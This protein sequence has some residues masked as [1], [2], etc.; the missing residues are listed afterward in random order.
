MMV[1]DAGRGPL[2]RAALTGAEEAGR[3]DETTTTQ[4]GTK[5]LH[6]I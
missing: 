1:I 6:K 2:V 4:I 3:F 5:P